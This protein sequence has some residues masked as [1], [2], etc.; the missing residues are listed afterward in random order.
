MDNT[1]TFLLE[2]GLEELPTRAVYD[3]SRALG[4]ALS[5]GLTQQGIAH[6]EISVF[7]TPRRIAVQIT[8]LAEQQP[9]QHV[10]RRGPALK[11][12]F[13]S[14]GNPTKA[15]LGFASSCGVDMDAIGRLETDKGVWLHYAATRPGEATAELLPGIID[16][17]VRGLPVA[18]RMRWGAHTHAF[19]RPLKWLVVLFGASVIDMTL[20]DC[21]SDRQ[22]W[23]HRFLAPDPIS[24]TNAEEYR[25][26][27]ESEGRVIADFTERR[28]RIAAAVESFAGA[29]GT[30]VIEP[31]LLDE[32][33]SLVEWPVA[34]MGRFDPDF[35][36]VPKE[37]LIAVMQDHQKY[38]H[39]VQSDGELAPA[40]VFISNLESRDPGSVI[41]GNE[42]V[43]APR[44]AD[45]RFFYD[46]DRQTPLAR[47]AERLASVTYQK[48]LGSLAQK[49]E[50]VTKL[51][52]FLAESM[53]LDVAIT[54]RAAMLSRCDLTSSIVFEFP[55]LQGI[56][57]RYYALSDGESP[58]VADA[59]EA[60]YHPRHATDALPAGREAQA[61][62]IADRLDT[63]VGIFGI[64]Q[65]PSG[66]RDPFGLRR[67]ALGVIR[68]AIEA[69]FDFDL[70]AALAEASSGLCECLGT[71]PEVADVHQFILERLRYWYQEREVDPSVFTAVA[72]LPIPRLKDFD[73]RIRA[74]AT[75]SAQPEAAA[76][77]AAN[78][79]SSNLLR[80]AADAG[81][82]L[83][84]DPS[85]LGSVELQ[86][87]QAIE[88]AKTETAPLLEKG[89]YTAALR[90]MSVLRDPV[91]AFFD[92]VMVVDPDPVLRANRL[93]LLR[94]LE[95]LFRAVADIGALN[96]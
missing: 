42:R 40:F 55:E 65:P 32:V 46:R 60:F 21:T 48:R 52:V 36:S 5:A 62:A 76:L 50:R 34:L 18:K 49:T 24:L 73:D 68:I 85:R 87:A 75:F 19:V 12:A 43:I 37:A 61:L 15:A 16:T 33:T 83:A 30:P 79:R 2:L 41:R 35:L 96:A 3:L 20:F 53:A 93:G 45:A 71:P 51:A 95:T 77:A 74:V 26:R 64:G 6:G 54:A 78:K 81:E 23:G 58:A 11:A 67:A 66:D 90:R 91:D 38:F 14:D 69:D 22:T 72:A 57:G 88:L 9:T 92:G 10:E 28:A 82:A 7:G 31:A 56:A 8:A 27:L 44:L 84:G 59:I 63:L 25:A 47:R 89:D 86:L 29:A 39:L 17:A 13:D 80:K 1:R 70:D 4:E 94:E